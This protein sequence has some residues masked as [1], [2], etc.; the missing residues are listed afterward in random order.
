M[1]HSYF[2]DPKSALVFRTG[3]PFDQAGDPQSLNFPLPSTTA[4]ACRTAIADSQ[5]NFDFNSDESRKLLLQNKVYGPLAASISNDQSNEQIKVF[6]P[7]PNDAVYLKDMEGNDQLFVLKPGSMTNDDE[8][9]CDLPKGIKPI[10]LEENIKSKP[11]DGDSWWSKSNM[12]RWLMGEKPTVGL[13]SLGWAGAK[14]ESRTHVK[15]QATTLAAEE[16]QLFQTQGID[17]ASPKKSKTDYKGWQDQRFGLLVNLPDQSIIP[18]YKRV[19]GEGR[20]V[21]IKSADSTWPTISS[22]LKDQLANTIEQKNKD[23]QENKDDQENDAL[24]IR[25]ILVTPAIFERGETPGWIDADT[26][27]GSPPGF[28]AISLK[29]IT[30]ANARW[31]AQ[32]GWDLALNKPRAIRRMVPAGAV[33]W[34]KVLAGAEHLHQLWL[35]PI[36]DREQ[37]GRDGFGLVL[38]GIW[39]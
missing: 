24:G 32:S 34:F 2:L 16:R 27:I 9:Y 17:F 10:F 37:D 39:K 23:K 33:Y 35:Q 6:F 25:L 4:G 8:E 31:E 20:V 18:Q 3:R 21:A 29:L 11:V 7:R 15:L 38:P 36:C 14:A 12:E 19:G 13:K 26:L 28:D 5:D 1:T 22:T 30:M